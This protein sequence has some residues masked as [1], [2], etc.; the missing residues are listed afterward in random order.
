MY[1]R[2]ADETNPWDEPEREASVNLSDKLMDKIMKEWK[3][4]LTAV[5]VSVPHG[6]SFSV[7]WPGWEVRPERHE[8]PDPPELPVERSE[9][10]IIG[11]RSWD[12]SRREPGGWDGW[13]GQWVTIDLSG[14]RQ[15]IGESEPEPKPEPEGPY[16]LWSPVQG[17]E[18]TGPILRADGKP[19]PYDPHAYEW[20]RRE[21]HCHGIYAHDEP[22]WGDYH[23]GRAIGR[24]EATGTVVIHEHGFRAEAVRITQLVLAPNLIGTEAKRDIERIYGCD[25]THN[26]EELVNGHR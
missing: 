25:V 24:L 9:T 23:Q 15:V 6:G 5:P 19:C 16:R 1:E 22:T 10:P 11:Y 8:P 7:S 18:W 2:Y 12:V 21:D 14:N 26:P 20:Q 13:R 3:K 17:T 4:Q